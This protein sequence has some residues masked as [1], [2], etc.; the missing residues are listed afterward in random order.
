MKTINVNKNTCI[1]CGACVAIDPEHF[2]FNEEGL[3][4]AINN[5][6]LES[7]TLKSAIDSCPTSAI[8]IEEAECA[9]DDCDCTDCDCGDD[10]ECGCD[11]CHCTEEDNCGCHCYE[12]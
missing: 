4:S 2:E 7:E 5:D 9:C 8:S 11:D 3:S 6:N 1:G 12:K 10:C